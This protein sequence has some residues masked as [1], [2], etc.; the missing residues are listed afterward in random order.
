MQIAHGEKG[1]WSNLNAGTNE[2][3]MTF[4]PVFNTLLSIIGWTLNY[5]YVKK[6]ISYNN[7]FKIK[8]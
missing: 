1:I 2:V 8:K 6:S 5:P 4:A 7:F 3:I